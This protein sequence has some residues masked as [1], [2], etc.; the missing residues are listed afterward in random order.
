[1][2]MIETAGFGIAVGNAVDAIKKAADAVVADCDHD[3]AAEAIEK[4]IL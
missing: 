1:M 2:S 4:F 3:G